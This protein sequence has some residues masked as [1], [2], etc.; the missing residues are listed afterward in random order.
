MSRK[1]FFTKDKY[2]KDILTDSRNEHPVMME[3]EKPY[4]E[5]MV[6]KLNPFGDV[7]E[8]GFGLG[9][10][11]NAI[12]EYDINTHT[13][14]ECDPTVLKRTYE[15]TKKQ[16]HEVI[17]VEGF[18]QEQLPLM[19]Q[20]FDSFFFDDYPVD[21]YPESNN[22]RFFDFVD[23]IVQ[24]NVNKNARLTHFC[25]KK[26]PDELFSIVEPCHMVIEVESEEYD[27]PIPED[28]FKHWSGENL[29]LSLFTFQTGSP[30]PTGRVP[31]ATDLLRASHG[32]V[33]AGAS[34]DTWYE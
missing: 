19:N 32:R 20:R 30:I 25:S 12:Q 2:G 21:N 23:M 34:G 3:M 1:I 7:L 28:T 11:A 22:S 24:K 13:I 17:I 18:W 31:T 9:Y 8:I 5:A 27:L 29:Y 10:S 33:H 16:K 14:I 15:W 4:M 26:L 6:N